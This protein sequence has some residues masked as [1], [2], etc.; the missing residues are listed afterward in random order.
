[1]NNS[2]LDQ[3]APHDQRYLG[4]Q[5][6]VGCDCFQIWVMTFNGETVTNAIALE[7]SVVNALG[8]YLARHMTARQK[9]LLASRLKSL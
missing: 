9:A 6:Y 3:Y 2:A 8:E 4:D 1:M 7:A 5:V